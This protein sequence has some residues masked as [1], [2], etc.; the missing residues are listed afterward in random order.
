M[1]DCQSV[2]TEK[3]KILCSLNAWL[4]VIVE[5]SLEEPRVEIEG[6]VEG[7]SGESAVNRIIEESAAKNVIE[8]S[9][10]KRQRIEAGMV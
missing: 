2:R 7:S 1:I 5:M 8:E 9:A 6:S 4:K 10:A 3:K